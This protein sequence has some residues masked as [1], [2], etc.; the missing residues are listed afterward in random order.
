MNRDLI[1]QKC[2]ELCAEMLGIA[3]DQCVETASFEDDLGADS[4]DTVEI[5]MQIEEVFKI[6][7]SE[8]ESETVHTFGDLV[9]LVDRIL[10]K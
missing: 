9:N 8:I 2:A 6:E 1:A 5:T 10:N 3:V 4:L 7:I